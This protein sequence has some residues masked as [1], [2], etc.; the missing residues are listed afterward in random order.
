MSMTNWGTGL[1]SWAVWA[2][3]CVHVA[4]I[5]PS[6]ADNWELQLPNREYWLAGSQK[7][8]KFVVILFWRA[9]DLGG[10]HGSYSSSMEA[11]GQAAALSAFPSVCAGKKA[12]P[13][14]FFKENKLLLGPWIWRG[15]CHRVSNTNKKLSWAKTSPV[16]VSH[17]LAVNTRD[18]SWLVWEWEGMQSPS[19]KCCFYLIV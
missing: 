1:A 10:S 8:G 14:L 7:V 17:S 12:W 18:S 6:Q 19:K 13:F 3:P 16:L 15:E 11:Q 9:R 4:L 5:Q 2:A